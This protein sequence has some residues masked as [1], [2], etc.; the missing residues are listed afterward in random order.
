[1][2]LKKVK[3]FRCLIMHITPLGVL[4]FLMVVILPHP[5]K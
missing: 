1:M 2:Y 5:H 3:I 4:V